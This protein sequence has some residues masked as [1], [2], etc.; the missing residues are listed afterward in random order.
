MKI[1]SDV[2][3]RISWEFDDQMWAAL[4]KEHQDCDENII[5][6]TRRTLQREMSTPLSGPAQ[7]VVTSIDVK[8]EP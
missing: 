2:T 7:H 3:I 4:R 1:V 6:F 8:I 5:E